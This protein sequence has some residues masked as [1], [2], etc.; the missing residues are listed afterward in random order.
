MLTQYP[1]PHGLGDRHFTTLLGNIYCGGWCS[2]SVTQTFLHCFPISSNLSPVCLV[3]Y[4]LSKACVQGV[5]FVFRPKMFSPGDRV[6]YHSRT[7]GAHVLATVV[8]PSPN[9][10]Q[11]CHI[12]YLRPGGATQVDHESAQFSRLEAVVVA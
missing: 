9:G 10:P 5:V 3:I 4:S 11:F 8:G 12:Q 2:P 1:L 7:L 6:W